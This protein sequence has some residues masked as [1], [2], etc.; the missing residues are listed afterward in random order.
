M[1]NTVSM[2]HSSSSPFISESCVVCM[3]L[4]AEVELKPCA[5][6]VICRK[7]ISLLEDKKCPVCR[8]QVDK[9]RIRG[10]SNVYSLDDMKVRPVE[11]DKT[12]EKQSASLEGAMSKDGTLLEHNSACKAS[13]CNQN[14]VPDEAYT[15]SLE[16]V[17]ERRRFH[18]EMIRKHAYQVVVTGSKDVS[19]HSFASCLQELFPVKHEPSF[20]HDN[21]EWIQ[22]SLYRFLDTGGNSETEE[23]DMKRALTLEKLIDTYS[24]AE[25]FLP[26]MEVGGIPVHLEGLSIWEL[27]YNL[28]CHSSTGFDILVLCCNALSKR[29][30]EEL[31]SLDELLRKR[32]APHT[33][34]IWVVLNYDDVQVEHSTDGVRREIIESELVRIPGNQRPSDLFFL[35]ENSLFK[36]W[37]RELMSQ[38]IHHAQKRRELVMVDHMEDAKK[39]D[40]CSCM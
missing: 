29:S 37:H 7:C 11:D 22:Q 28:R 33:T 20:P 27:L 15:F 36:F 38:I 3:D 8:S 30:F 16:A 40:F 24:S 31:L 26:N 32:Y 2:N 14:V 34:R 10:F 18:E 17:L 4:T 23:V 25:S 21:F 19:F 5:H 6:A 1:M 13:P 12:I 9:I 39:R 35:R